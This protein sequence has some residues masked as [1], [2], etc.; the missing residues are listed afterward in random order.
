MVST[1]TP[2]ARA[3]SSIRYSMS[4]HSNCPPRRSAARRVAGAVAQGH[5]QCGL[6]GAALDHEGNGV[7]GLVQLQHA[8]H[9]LAV[10]EVG[11]VD[12]LDDIVAPQASAVGRAAADH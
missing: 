12:S 7:T 1:A 11:A 9:G 8:A 5:A 3:N 6:A 2:A 10:V 4:D